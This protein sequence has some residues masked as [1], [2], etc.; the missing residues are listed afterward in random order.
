ML[1]EPYHSYSSLVFFDPTRRRPV[2]QGKGNLCS[3][4]LHSLRSGLTKKA[5]S[6]RFCNNHEKDK[7]NRQRRRLQ[8]REGYGSTELC[9]SR[10]L[11]PARRQ[12]DRKLPR[13]CAG[14]ITPIHRSP[15]STRKQRGCSVLVFFLQ[16]P[17]MRALPGL[18]RG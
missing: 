4:P 6:I 2:K 16:S 3:K 5:H 8:G 1:G 10:N 13:H 12:V 18:H 17:R 15:I 11:C 14:W 9:V 7:H